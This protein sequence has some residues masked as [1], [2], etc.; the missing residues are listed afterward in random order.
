L[1]LNSSGLIIFIYS[2]V[3]SVEL[4][5]LWIWRTVICSLD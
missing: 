3:F 1:S 5:D 4:M 2:V